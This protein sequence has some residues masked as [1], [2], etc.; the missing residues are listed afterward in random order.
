[1]PRYRTELTPEEAL[2]KLEAER[3]RKRDYYRNK[4]L[5]EGKELYSDM[6]RPRI[7]TEEEKKQHVKEYNRMYYQKKKAER[8]ANE[9]AEA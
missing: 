5:A 3:N 8:L 6:G 1:M 2:A 7:R 4:V 9:K